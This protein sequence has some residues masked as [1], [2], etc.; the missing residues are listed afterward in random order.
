MITLDNSKKPAHMD[1]TQ[2]ARGK[3]ET[4]LAIYKIEGD[5]LTICFSRGAR[6]QPSSERPTGFES[7]EATKSDL[8]V[9]KRKV[10]ANE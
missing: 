9:L 8:L 3:T 7:D 1:M 4:V 6:G 5:L 2:T 10:K